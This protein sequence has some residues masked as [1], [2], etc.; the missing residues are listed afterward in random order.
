MVKGNLF[1][2]LAFLTFIDR[3]PVPSN[4]LSFTSQGISHKHSVVRKEGKVFPIQ[5]SIREY[6]IVK[7]K[8]ARRAF[9]PSFVLQLQHWSSSLRLPFLFASLTFPSSFRFAYLL[10]H[11]LFS[12]IKSLSNYLLTRYLQKAYI[13]RFMSYSLSFSLPS[14]DQP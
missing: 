12:L 7:E 9:Q 10:F 14:L 3:I 5:N 2:S 13:N 8:R 4:A 1:F 11:Y 6:Q